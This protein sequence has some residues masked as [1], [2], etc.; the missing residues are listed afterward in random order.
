MWESVQHAYH[1]RIVVPGREPLF[2]LLIGLVAAF[3]FIRFSTRMIRRGTSW[4]PGNV[5]PGGLHIHHVVF[6][7]ALMVVAGIGGFTYHGAQAGP[8]DVLATAFG[9]GCGLVLDEFALVLHLEDVYWKEQG[10]KSVDAVIL[11]VALIALLLLGQLPFGGYLGRPGPAQLAAVGILLLLVV[12][13]LL[14]GKLW[15]GLIGVMIPLLAVVGAIRLARPGSPWARWRYRTRPKRMARAE[16]REARVHRRVTAAKVGAYNLLA[17]APDAERATEP[18]TAAQPAPEPAPAPLPAPEPVPPRPLPPWRRRCAVFAEWYLRIAAALNLLAGVVAPFRERVDR[19]NTGDLFTPVLVTAGFTA[20]LF[21]ALLAVMLRR[22]KR[23]AWI[24]ATAVAALYTVVAALALAVLPEDR[25]HPFNWISAAL[26]ALLLAALLAGKRAFHAR[27]ARGNLALGLTVLVVGGVLVTSLGALLVRVGSRPRA[28]WG[29]CFNYAL[30]RLFTVSGFGQAA[31]RLTVDRWADLAVNVL[32]AALFLLV[33]RVFFRSPHG[34]VHLEPEDERRLRA[35]LERHGARDSL[36]YFALRRDKSVCWSPSGKAAVLYR[37]VNGVALASGDPIGDPEAWPQA[38]GRW[39]ELA[40]VN[41]WVPA[42]TGAGEQAATVY[43]RTGLKAL[44]F[45]DE[46]IVQVSDFGLEGRSMRTLRQSRNRV[47]KGGYRALVRRHSEIP[48]AE[49]D[50]LVH[51]ADAWRHGRTERG[52]SMALGRL[53]DPADGDCVLAE[54]R[55]ENGRTCALLSFVPWGAHGLS[56]DLMRRDRESPNGLVEFLVTELLLSAS[57]GTLPVTRVSLNF[58]MFRYVFE[59]GGKLGAGPVLRLCRAVL[60]GLSR[61]WQ[62]ESLYRANAKYQPQWEPRFVL[63]EK[64]SELPTIAVAAGLA[65]GFLVR[66]RL[67]SVGS[68]RRGTAAHPSG[69]APG[70]GSSGSRLAGPR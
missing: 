59:Q 14:K 36:G 21:A 2:L 26:T 65:E 70:A 55:D 57:T 4:W 43:R 48:E 62:L 19:A 10:R 5:T 68:L 18:G 33:L 50:R 69:G 20:A 8:R 28:D 51:L 53:G 54:C 67:P 41:A 30:V 7:Q 66:P 1:S 17:G 40:R 58:A 37:V 12:I 23:A 63:Y 31:S 52:F 49:L 47:R 11:A 61:W 45:G 25:A 15:T 6:G 34:R 22:R 39:R 44:E 32:G 60:R 64:S 29:D 27:G 24:V 46:A 35:L 16:R 13:S 9:A 56:L 3:L 38:I 42:V